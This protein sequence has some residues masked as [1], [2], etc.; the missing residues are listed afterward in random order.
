MRDYF[1][2]IFD[3]GV[4]EGNDTDYY[5]Q[6]GFRVIA[7]EADPEMFE[8]LKLR[9]QS[10]I[11]DGSLKLLNFAASDTFGDQVDFFTCTLNQ[12]VS[13]VMINKDVKDHYKASVPVLTIDW[14]TLVAQGR[15]YYVKIDIEGNEKKFLEGMVQSRVIP[16]F[17]SVECHTMEPVLKL[18]EIG[19]RRFQLVDQNCQVRDEHSGSG[20]RLPT[21]QLEGIHIAKPNF[22][23]ASGPFGRDVFGFDDWMDIEG[24]K[25]AWEANQTK[26]DHSWFDC[27]AWMPRQ[28]SFLQRFTPRRKQS[29]DR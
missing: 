20:F 27:H 3:L 24:F 28:Q 17:I 7:V 16:E 11:K 1:G 23:H 8:K 26:R 2:L 15:P 29:M 14:K 22:Y 25:V 21:T 12:G 18:H 19:Y 4:S 5:L 9:F 10:A 6:K 13:G